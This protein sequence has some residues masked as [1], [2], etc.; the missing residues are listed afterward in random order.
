MPEEEKPGTNAAVAIVSY[1]YWQKQ[2]LN[3]ALLNSQ[4]T[5]NNR[6][7]HSDRNFAEGIHRHDGSFR[8]RK[9]GCRSALMITVANDFESDNRTTL[10]D[11]TGTQLLI[12]G[13]MKPGMTAARQRSQR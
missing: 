8:A 4:I 3:P 2:N 6:P 12:V 11:R 9:F 13:R 10:G 7:Y 5:V 1:S